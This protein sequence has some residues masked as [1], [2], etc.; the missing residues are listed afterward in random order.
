MSCISYHPSTH[1]GTD[2]GSGPKAGINSYPFS[3]KYSSFS[4]L[5]DFPLALSPYN[6]PLSALQISA[7]RSPPI[8]APVGSTSPRTAF[9][10]IAASM[11]L[12]PFFNISSAT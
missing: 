1:P 10:A 11:A 12:P 5:G 2:T 9:A 3:L 7:K 8:P 4:D 6:F